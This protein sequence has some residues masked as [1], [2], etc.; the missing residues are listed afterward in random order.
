MAQVETILGCGNAAGGLASAIASDETVVAIPAG[1]DIT[2]NGVEMKA[3]GTKSAVN[4]LKN[5]SAK[6][7]NNKSE[8]KVEKSKTTESV[9]GKFTKTTEVRP[10]KGSGQS[11]AE[12]VRYK[13]KDGKV[14]RTHKDSYDRANKFQHRKPLR[15]GPEGRP[16]N[17]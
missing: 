1:A 5:Q 10:G 4:G 3:P 6:I 14:I 9:G 7:N 8:S 16:Q 2:V 15:G 13:N 11:R 12:Y 17:D